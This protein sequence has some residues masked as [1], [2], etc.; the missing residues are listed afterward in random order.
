MSRLTDAASRSSNTTRDIYRAFTRLFLFVSRFACFP[1][2]IASHSLGTRRQ[3]VL[4]SAMFDKG[5]F[6]R[7][8]TDGVPY[9]KAFLH[10]MVCYSARLAGVVCFYLCTVGRARSRVARESCTRNSKLFLFVR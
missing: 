4:A 5:D 2:S 9:T 1:R 8:E 10:S 7:R 6:Y 3:L